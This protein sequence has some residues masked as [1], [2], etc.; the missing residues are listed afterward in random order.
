MKKTYSLIELTLKSKETFE[1]PTNKD[2]DTLIASSDGQFFRPKNKSAANFHKQQTGCALYDISRAQMEAAVKKDTEIRAKAE[3]DKIAN[4]GT[5]NK[6]ETETKV[7]KP[8]PKPKP[9][10]KAPK[11]EAPKKEAGDGKEEAPEKKADEPE[12]KG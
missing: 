12:S 2:V 6:Q 3:A 8:K 11:K 4:S 1:H 9:R 10:T 7:E 5:D